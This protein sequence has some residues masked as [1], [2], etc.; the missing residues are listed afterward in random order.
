MGLTT[1]LGMGRGQEAIWFGNATDKGT[2][3]RFP[4]PQLRGEILHRQRT[5]SIG[6]AC[7]HTSHRIRSRS[8]KRIQDPSPSTSQY[9]TYSLSIRSIT[10]VKRKQ[11]SC[12][13]RSNMKPRKLKYG[14]I[15][16]TLVGLGFS[17][18]T[19]KSNH[20]VYHHPDSRLP[21]FLPRM[22]R[23]RRRRTHRHSE[24]AMPSK[25]QGFGTVLSVRQE[26]KVRLRRSTCCKRLP[27]SRMGNMPESERPAMELA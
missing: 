6:F 21:I 13:P 24:S 2:R 20:L 15:R 19:T 12:K 1:N 27:A 25:M 4:E 16:K 23:E 8:P 17:E 9:K 14:E 26:P 18:Q 7:R 3:Y 11:K 5:H 10:C 22:R